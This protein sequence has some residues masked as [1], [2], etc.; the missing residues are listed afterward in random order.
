[1]KNIR[2]MIVIALS[3]VM[4]FAGCNRSGIKTDTTPGKTDGTPESQDLS[5]SKGYEEIGSEAFDT[6]GY[7]LSWEKDFTDYYKDGLRVS[8][9]VDADRDESGSLVLDDGQSWIVCAEIKGK[10]Y[11]LFPDEFV[12]LG[13]LDVNVYLDEEQSPYILLAF[14]GTASFDLTEFKY[15]DGKLLK[16]VVLEDSNLNYIGGSKI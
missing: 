7:A 4:V 9:Y 5:S 10:N 14:S 8:I 13:S 1:M 3:A 16:R 11:N 2:Y 15:S 12:Q 6:K